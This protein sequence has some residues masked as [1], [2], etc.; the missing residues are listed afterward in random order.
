M[1]GEFL[2]ESEFNIS[3][4][5]VTL[6]CLAEAPAPRQILISFMRRVL[7][8]G[9]FRELSLCNRALEDAK[10][11]FADGR[12][13][14]VRVLLKIKSLFEHSEPRYL[15][16]RLFI[17]DLTIW[18]QKVP[19]EDFA[20]FQEQVQREAPLSVEESGLDFSFEE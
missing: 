9:V 15:F 10:Q 12:L 14:L 5:S 18:L 2:C 16:N 7:V 11:L 8:Y 17:D 19:G 20:A 1:D 13:C 4:L 3:K 6:S